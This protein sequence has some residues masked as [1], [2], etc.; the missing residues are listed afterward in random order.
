MFGY[1]VL[2]TIICFTFRGSGLS[3]E[4]KAE[5]YDILQNINRVASMVKSINKS[6]KSFAMFTKTAAKLSTA[7]NIFNYVNSGHDMTTYKR[8][9]FVADN[10]TDVPLNSTTE[11]IE[12]TVSPTPTISELC[13]NHSQL[14]SEA[15]QRQDYWAMRMVDAAGKPSS[16]ILSG[17]LMWLGSYDECLE[18]KVVADYNNITYRFDG[19]YC[20]VYIVPQGELSKVLPAQSVIQLGVCVPD[21]CSC[22]SSCLYECLYIHFRLNQLY[23]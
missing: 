2:L 7:G 16:N 9:D 22:I 23:S 1:V 3:Q 4:G 13:L 11:S 14:V 18:I 21:S 19:Q 6:P 5:H 12:T 17:G 8:D 15:L 10:V 20:K